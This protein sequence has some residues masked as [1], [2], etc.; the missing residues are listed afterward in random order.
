LSFD[1][2][3]GGDDLTPEEEARLRRVHELLVEAGPPP[4]L[5]PALLNPVRPTEAKVV[6]FPLLMKRRLAVVAIAA[7]AAVIVAFAIGFGV[8]HSKGKSQQFA[9][10]R[11]VPMHGT[12]GRHGVIQIGK[13]DDAGN[14]PMAVAVTGLPQQENAKAYYELWLTRDGKPVAPCG[15]FRV[16]GAT[17]TVRLSVP[18]KL[19]GFDGWVVTAQPASDDRIGPVVLST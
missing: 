14:W 12:P 10:E 5:P 17:T 9:A 3:I 8:G 18:Y 7:A 1:D 6:E 4:D 15:S 11:S 16:H 19:H 2:L 13:A